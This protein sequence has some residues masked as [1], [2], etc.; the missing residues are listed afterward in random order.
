ML[1]QRFVLAGCQAC[2]FDLS[3]ED[4]ERMALDDLYL[5]YADSLDE[6]LTGKGQGLSNGPGIDLSSPEA[7]EEWYFDG[8]RFGG[9]PWEVCRGGSWTHVTLMV[10]N[11]RRDAECGR[12][13][14][15]ARTT[16]RVTYRSCV[17]PGQ[18]P[19]S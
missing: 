3:G 4:R 9:H 8:N 19:Y 13:L 18:R 16:T 10:C 2:G 15:A 14:V 1:L 7:W 6:G 11:D 5:H 12:R 17:I